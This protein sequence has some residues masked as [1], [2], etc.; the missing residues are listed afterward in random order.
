MSQ[1]FLIAVDGSDHAWKAVDIASNLAKACGAELLVVH[2]ASENQSVEGLEELALEGVAFEED[3]S[4][5]RFLSTLK[6]QVTIGAEKRLRR[7]GV[8]QLTVRIVEGRPAREIVA[9][10]KS[11]N[12]DMIFLG[13]RGRSDMVGL[14]LGSVSHK[15]MQTAPCTCIAVK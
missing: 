2:V 7:N 11:E 6:H 15:V 4:H 5:S 8:D 3:V 10:A 13:S 1:K 9:T 14:V 12:V